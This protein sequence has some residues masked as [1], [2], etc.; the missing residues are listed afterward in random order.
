MGA[1]VKELNIKGLLH[2]LCSEIFKNPHGT[3]VQLYKHQQIKKI[4]GVKNPLHYPIKIHKVK[5][6]EITP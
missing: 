5:C 6:L 2:P 4:I 1:T 3:P